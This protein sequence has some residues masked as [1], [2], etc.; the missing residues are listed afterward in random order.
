MTVI[1]VPENAAEDTEGTEERFGCHL[2]FL[3]RLKADGRV[4]RSLRTF[5]LFW[6]LS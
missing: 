5:L 2:G 6:A 4:S 1:P 3:L